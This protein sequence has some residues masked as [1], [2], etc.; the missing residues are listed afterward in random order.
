MSGGL[1]TCSPRGTV[2]SK[3]KSLKGK[4]LVPLAVLVVAMTTTARADMVKCKKADGSLYVGASPPENCVPVGTLRSQGGADAGSSWKAGG[5][6]PTPTPAPDPGIVNK[7][8]AEAAEKKAIEARRA[9]RAI[10]VQN[11]VN[12]VYRDGPMVEGTV[13]NGA[14]FP[15]YSVRI[16]FNHG[17]ACQFTAPSTVYPGATATFSFVAP[18]RE[19]PDYTIT[20]DVVPATE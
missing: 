6:L 8:E 12:K 5:F 2:T 16:C 7:A 11:M 17:Q 3:E 13:A 15:V 20:W 14:P 10:A 19:I 9:V 4:S 1:R 18:N